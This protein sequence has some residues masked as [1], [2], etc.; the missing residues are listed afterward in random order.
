MIAK[1]PGK[2]VAQGR[3]KQLTNRKRCGKLEK[4]PGS[5]AQDLEN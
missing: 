5:A 4:L 2:K 1:P 3:K